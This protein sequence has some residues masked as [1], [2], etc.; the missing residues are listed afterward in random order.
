M[1]EMSSNSC[2]LVVVAVVEFVVD[3]LATKMHA[4][5]LLRRKKH[6]I[7]LIVKRLQRFGSVYNLHHILGKQKLKTDKANK[8]NAWHGICQRVRQLNPTKRSRKFH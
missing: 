7:L 8:M 5:V 4:L 6:Q 3:A 1:N 2:W